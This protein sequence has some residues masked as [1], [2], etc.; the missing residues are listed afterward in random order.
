MII[1]L[2][3]LSIYT[4]ASISVQC[5]LALAQNQGCIAGNTTMKFKQE[6]LK[7]K[8]V[9]SYMW[10]I[11]KGMDL[12][13]R[14]AMFEPN[15]STDLIIYND[16]IFHQKDRI[17][18]SADEPATLYLTNLRK[19]DEGPYVLQVQT[20]ISYDGS[21]CHYDVHEYLTIKGRCKLNSSILCRHMLL[22]VIFSDSY[23]LLIV[24]CFR[25]SFVVDSHMFP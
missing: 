5:F 21:K 17:F 22:I 11:H 18:H 2:Q 16:D 4:I 25:K 1:F 12:F 23:M 14:Y 19:T 9:I 6:M 10:S 8:E 3:L 20:C 24:I 15:V 13:I 7:G